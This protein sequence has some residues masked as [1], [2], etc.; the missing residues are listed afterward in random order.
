MTDSTPITDHEL[1]D[2]LKNKQFSSHELVESI[3]PI[4]LAA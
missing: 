2:G 3:L 1:A 4:A